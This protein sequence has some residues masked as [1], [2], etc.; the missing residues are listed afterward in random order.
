MHKWA[1]PL[2]WVIGLGL[3]IPVGAL[4]KVSMNIYTGQ[5]SC[6]VWDIRTGT[7]DTGYKVIKKNQFLI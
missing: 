6:S 2:A 7:D 4:A 3:A 5:K 1:I